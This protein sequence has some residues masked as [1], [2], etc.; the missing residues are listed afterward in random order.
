MCF[1]ITCCIAIKCEKFANQIRKDKSNVFHLF[2]NIIENN[3][4]K[5][6]IRVPVKAQWKQIRLG[7]MR[8]CV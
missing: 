1:W 5:M 7:T 8:L 4:I 2:H 3:L 6:K